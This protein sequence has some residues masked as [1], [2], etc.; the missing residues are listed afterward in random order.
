MQNYPVQ[1]SQV[2][3]MEC[4][5]ACDLHIDT[6]SEQLSSN[7]ISRNSSLSFFPRTSFVRLLSLPSPRLKRFVQEFYENVNSARDIRFVVYHLY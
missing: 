3:E 2:S 1:T 6:N 5:G 7:V 4:T